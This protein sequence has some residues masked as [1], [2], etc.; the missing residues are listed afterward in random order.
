LPE[1]IALYCCLALRDLIPFHLL[2]ADVIANFV[3]T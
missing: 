2:A 3:I 1:G